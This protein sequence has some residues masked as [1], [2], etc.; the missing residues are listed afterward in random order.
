MLLPEINFAKRLITKNKLSPPINVFRLAERYATIEVFDLPFDVEGI[1]LNLKVPCKTPQILL[2][3][4]FGNPQRLRFTIAHELGHVLIP[5]HIGT[6]IDADASE[7]FD[8]GVVGDYADPAVLDAEANRF[9]SELLMPSEWLSTVLDPAADPEQLIST[10]STRADVSYQAATIKIIQSLPP[11]F[12][13]VQISDFGEVSTSARSPG[14]VVS[15]PA[16]GTMIDPVT[17]YTFF[18]KRYQFTL[19]GK[20]Y[21]WWNFAPENSEMTADD[22]RSWR[23]LLD[24]MMHDLGVPASDMSAYKKRINSTIAYANSVIK[25]ESPLSE[26]LFSAC[27]QRFDSHPELHPFVNHK[28]FKLFIAKKAQDLASRW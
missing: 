26:H 21:I 10:V 9:A 5:W 20:S 24:E 13:Y 11:G 6:I 25:H 12:V 3:S 8:A 14:T 22:P 1:S 27:I 7:F 15:P 4:V 18:S 23:E 28:S 19:G 17:V 2:N 16:W